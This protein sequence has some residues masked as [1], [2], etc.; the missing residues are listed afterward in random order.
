MTVTMNVYLNRVIF[1]ADNF[2]IVSVFPET[3]DEEKAN[4]YKPDAITV[5]GNIMSMEKGVKYRMVAE[6]VFDAKY[7]KQY[8]ASLLAPSRELGLY[9]IVALFKDVMSEKRCIEFVKTYPNEYLEILEKKDIQKLTA[10]KGIGESSAMSIFNRFEKYQSVLKVLAFVGA[11]SMSSLTAQRILDRHHGNVQETI[12]AIRENPYNLMFEVNGIGFDKADEIALRIGIPF[13]ST[14]RIKAI[15]FTSLK[16]KALSDGHTYLTQGQLLKS[17]MEKCEKQD[18]DKVELSNCLSESIKELKVENKI[19]STD[20]GER[21]CLKWLYNKEIMI[22]LCL[23]KLMEHKEEDESTP[24]SISDTI[25]CVE[26]AKGIIYTEEQRNAIETFLSTNVMMLTGGAGTGKTTTLMGMLASIPRGKTY[27]LCSLAGKAAARMSEVTGKYASTIHRLLGVTNDG[28]F[29]H[30]MSYKLPHDIVFVDE[31]S[32]VD[33]NLFYSLVVALKPSCKLVLIGDEGQLESIGVGNLFKNILDCSSIPT[34]R[35][36]QI[37]R[38][39]QKSAIITDSNKVR[40]GEQI[41]PPGYRGIQIHGELKDFLLCCQDDTSSVS[42]VAFKLFKSK[43]KETKDIKKVQV[44]TP[45]KRRGAICTEKLNKLCQSW[46]NPAKDGKEEVTVGNYIYRQGD[47]VIN[48]VNLYG[49]VLYDECVG[50][51][52]LLKLDKEQLKSLPSTDV[53][54]GFQG[55][56]LQIDKKSKSMLIDFDLCG[57]VWL[58]GQQVENLELGYACTVHSYQGSQCE[59]VI[60][61][62]DKASYILARKELVY[63]GITRASEFCALCTQSDILRKAISTS[64]VSAKQTYLG[65]LLDKNYDDERYKDIYL[66]SLM[67]YNGNDKEEYVEEISETDSEY[68]DD[69]SGKEVE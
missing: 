19:C 27:A 47:R 18:Y 12:K 30:C 42:A 52:D 38:Q 17:V 15:V 41:A 2:R 46:Y 43:L 10:I 49:A 68:F 9:D 36:T 29:Q 54:N 1:E 26:R 55:I 13:I 31:V 61:V 20:D 37:H 14:K 33:V 69:G 39:A 44:I 64:T 8:K 3:T 35:L 67:M 62:F 11:E 48:K 21:L 4:G 65:E 56:V 63:T 53:F 59:N 5:K 40:H 45:M 66:E 16:E 60:F 22:S 32:M 28:K 7:G 6:E 25:A 24:E 23:Q 34:V 57:K 51:D 58:L 50:I